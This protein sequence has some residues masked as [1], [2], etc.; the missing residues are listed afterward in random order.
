M[1][2][3]FDEETHTY[4][5]DGVKIPSVTQV[6]Q[7]NG[8]SDFSKVNPK[9]LEYAI[10]LG[11][12]VHYAAHLDDAGELD[13]STVDPEVT[14]RLV[15]WRKFRATLEIGTGDI[16]HSEGKLYSKMGFA[17]TPD[18]VIIYPK[19]ALIVDIKT[20]VKTCAA[21]VQTAGYAIQ[22]TENYGVKKI[23]R[24]GVYLKA[25]GYTVEE[26]RNQLDDAVF[27]SCLNLYKYKQ[28]RG[29]L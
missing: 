3:E 11:K 15:Q 16:I 20:G 26:H 10:A 24:I 9:A 2:L 25:D 12:A 7:A 8:L 1:P 28:E 21:H 13:E 4:T 19:H 14:A 27:K 18:R 22:V 6:I 23:N 17:G 29:I 5:L